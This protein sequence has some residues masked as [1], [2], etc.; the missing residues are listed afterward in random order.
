MLV[1]ASYE[2][3]KGTSQVSGDGC[4]VSFD[5]MT[6]V[7]GATVEH[8]RDLS[9]PLPAAADMASGDTPGWEDWDGDDK[10]GISLYISGDIKGTMY[11]VTRTTVQ[12][13][14]TVASGSNAIRLPVIWNQSRST[15]GIDGSPLLASDGGPDPDPAQA[16]VQLA[17]LTAEQAAGAPEAICTRM[18]EL[19]PTLTPTTMN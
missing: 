1:H 9:V 17:R 14:G 2:G 5:K 11:A 13:S 15:L 10:P 7:R 18:R 4:A 12:A 19:A 3:R 6:L 16:Y 8:Y